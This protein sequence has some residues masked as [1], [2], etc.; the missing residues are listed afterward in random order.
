MVRRLLLV[1]V[2]LAVCLAWPGG[3]SAV[4]LNCGDTVTT[5]TVVDNDIVCSNPDDIGLIIGAD[6]I[7]VQFAQ[8][9]LQ[10]PSVAGGGS[11][12]VTDDGTPH[13]G[14]TIRRGPLTD[15][16]DGES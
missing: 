2:V 5:N 1:G 15:I 6:N 4:T 10:G 14:V 12:G 11:I 3:A 8:H 9:T 16:G 7:T 13:T